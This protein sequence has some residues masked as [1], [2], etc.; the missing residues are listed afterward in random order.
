MGMFIPSA[1]QISGLGVE[2]GRFIPNPK[3]IKDSDM[4]N[5]FMYGFV[6]G[7]IFKLG[8]ILATNLPSI[9]WKFLLSK[10]IFNKKNR[11]KITMD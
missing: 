5:F 2:R 10:K 7:L 11:S 6:I 1:N 8:D 9:F 3:A 4:R